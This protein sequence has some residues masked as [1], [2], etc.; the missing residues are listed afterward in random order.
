MDDGDTIKSFFIFLAVAR[1]SYSEN[2]VICFLSMVF[3]VICTFVL[4]LQSFAGYVVRR[5]EAADAA[6][7]VAFE[8][9]AS[10][11]RIREMV[12]RI[13]EAEKIRREQEKIRREKIREQ[14]KIRR[15]KIREQEKIRREKIREE[16]RKHTIEL[17]QLAPT[18]S[19]NFDE[20]PF[21]SAAD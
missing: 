5:A 13:Y 6:A 9:A 19:K 1:F 3:V 10:A 21:F 14:E 7:K 2:Y 11:A 17:G 20:L 15:E 18:I 16:I 8:E 12:E 4:V